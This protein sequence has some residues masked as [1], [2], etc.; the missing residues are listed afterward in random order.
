MATASTQLISI[1][2]TLA[3]AAPG[4]NSAELREAFEVFTEATA[5]FTATYESLRSRARELDVELAETNKRLERNLA[6][7]ER[8]K[9]YLTAILTTLPAGVVVV[10]ELGRV[11][12]VNPAARE[13]LGLEGEEAVGRPLREV[14]GRLSDASTVRRSLEGDF[15]RGRRVEIAV[16]DGQGDRRDLEVVFLAA[17]R[18]T[19]S[20]FGGVIVFH[21]VTQLKRLE[22]QAAM[23]SRLTAMGEMAMN[24]A[25]EIRNPLGSIELFASALARDLA[26]R[27]H[28]RQLAEHVSAGVRSIESIVENILQF[29]RPR[30]LDRRRVCLPEAVEDSLRYADHLLRQREID[31]RVCRPSGPLDVFGGAEAGVLEPGLERRPGH[32]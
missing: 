5:S 32:G 8:V 31:A 27:P 25:H 24:V 11:K 1:P 14:F 7:K 26:D 13:M 16:T 6:E 10:D 22:Q 12:T 21:D 17:S 4:P 30:R 9:E 2:G 3:G 28:Q 23:V 19:R 20:V 18:E 29:N 15:L